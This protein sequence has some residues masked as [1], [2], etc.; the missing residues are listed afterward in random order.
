VA[1]T[2]EEK[3]RVRDVVVGLTDHHDRARLSVSSIGTGNQR[4]GPSTAR[5]NTT[6]TRGLFVRARVSTH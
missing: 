1:D 5:R 4:D 2:D 3:E 6:G